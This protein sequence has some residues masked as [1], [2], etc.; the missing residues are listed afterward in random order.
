MDDV[1]DVRLVDAHAEGVRRDHDGRAVAEERLLIGLPF[2]RL[3]SRVIARGR[4]A[5]GA[6]HAADG[7]HALARGAV[8]NAAFLPARRKK[9]QKRCAFVL[10]PQHL[11][12]EVRPVKAGDHDLR[13]LQLQDPDDILAHLPRGRRG[14]CRQRRAA[15]ELL[16]ELRDL[17]IARAEIL[18]PLRDAVCL[19]D[20]D[21]RNVQLL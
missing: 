11:K 16:Q 19:V 17:Q 20:G 21:K 8:D 14:K 5:L 9:L 2:L 15:R 6:Q 13:A 4:E 18:P 3:Q 1:G 7:L 12:A 10:R